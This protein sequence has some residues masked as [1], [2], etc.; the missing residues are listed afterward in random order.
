MGLAELALISARNRSFPLLQRR[1]CQG[2]F[3]LDQMRALEWRCRRRPEAIDA[4]HPH[5][6][7]RSH[8]RRRHRARA[9]AAGLGG[10]V[11]ARAVNRSEGRRR[12]AG[13]HD[14]D[15][16]V[17]RAPSALSPARRRSACP[18]RSTR[19]TCRAGRSSRC[20]CAWS[21]TSSIRS[22]SRARASRRAGDE[23]PILRELVAEGH[24]VQGRSR[25]GARRDRSGRRGARQRQP[26]AEAHSQRA[27]PETPE[28]ARHARTVHAR[29][30]RRS[31][32]RTRSSP[33]ATDDSC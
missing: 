9:D 26:R 14:R 22:I 4:S 8:R 33:S 27:A 12:R 20:S 2:D 21:P 10:A 19:S 29:R 1:F 17:P 5:A 24:R 28:A 11:G 15:G 25:R 16:E 6:R 30:R 18:M 13:G 23:F 31:T 3:N 7:I 32:C